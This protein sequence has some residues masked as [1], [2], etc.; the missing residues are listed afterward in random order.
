MAKKTEEAHRNQLGELQRQVQSL[1]EQYQ[2]ADKERAQQL[3]E[4]QDENTRLLAAQ[5]HIQT[6]SQSHSI[7]HEN[8]KVEANQLRAHIARL[9]Q[10]LAKSESQAAKA[11]EEAAG[12]K[13]EVAKVEHERDETTLRI[14][15]ME[16]GG[17]EQLLAQ[18]DHFKHKCEELEK[19][20]STLRAQINNH[21]QNRDET[22]RDASSLR[23]QVEELTIKLDDSEQMNAN[24]K[25]KVDELSKAKDTSAAAMQTR[26]FEYKEQATSLARERDTLAKKLDEILHEPSAPHAPSIPKDHIHQRVAFV[27][28]PVPPSSSP[29][30]ISILKLHLLIFYLI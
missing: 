28:S 2:A 5:A 26:I 1:I 15:E 22:D 14:A 13:K 17:D 24:L 21:S 27:P 29:P 7:S 20:N 4:L 10:Q 18:I 19:D 9:E 12:L 30:P 11:A 16:T 6:Q 25:A 3:D 8:A 23:S